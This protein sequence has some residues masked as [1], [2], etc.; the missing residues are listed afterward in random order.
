MRSRIHSRF[1]RI[2]SISASDSTAIDQTI[3]LIFDEKHSFPK[4]SIGGS[5]LFVHL[6]IK[7]K[8]LL[9]CSKDKNQPELNQL[10]S[11]GRS[12]NDEKK[13]FCCHI[14]Q[15]NEEE[16]VNQ[17]S[18]IIDYLFFALIWIA[19]RI[20]SFSSIQRKKR[21]GFSNSFLSDWLDHPYI[22]NS[23]RT[24]EQKQ[25]ENVARFDRNCFIAMWCEWIH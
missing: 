13:L 15:E 6:L 1:L 4:M 24:G 22:S 19:T 18:V 7:N 5:V 10:A 8:S 17:Y 25:R 12:M 23:Q 9:F 11:E 21:R 14:G 16:T 3:L 2:T 20:S